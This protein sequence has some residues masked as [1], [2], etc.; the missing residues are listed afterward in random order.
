MAIVTLN[1]TAGFYIQ[2][3][4]QI[5]TQQS[6]IYFAQCSLIVGISLVIMQ[7]AISR[8]LQ[9][10]VQRLLWTGL[11]FMMLGLLISIRTTQIHIFQSAYILYGLA[12]AC[13]TPAFTTGAA[14][15][16]P[17][18]LQAKI[19]SFCTATQALSFVFGP[20]ISTGLYQL[21]SDYPFYLLILMFMFL[22]AYFIYY[23][24]MMQQSS[25]PV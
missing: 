7:T 19:A 4:F 17:R 3:Q 20:L 18:H 9:W 14:Q 10:S 2:D 5:S 1:L 8:F 13:L 21:H 23:Q 25:V 15:S 12:V 22:A 16:A 11:V 6:A 24:K